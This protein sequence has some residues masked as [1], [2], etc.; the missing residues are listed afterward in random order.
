MLNDLLSCNEIINRCV[1]EFELS[2]QCRLQ[3]GS[4]YPISRQNRHVLSKL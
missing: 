1:L 4:K 3:G 2:I